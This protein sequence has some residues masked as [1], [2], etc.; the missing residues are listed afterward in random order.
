MKTL[1]DIG[2]VDATEYRRAHG[3]ADQTAM[4][5]DD[6]LSDRDIKT[7]ARADAAVKRTGLAAS[8]KLE[9]AAEAL[10]EFLHACLDAG[11][12]DRMGAGDGR[13][14]LMQSIMEY[15]SYLDGV[16]GKKEH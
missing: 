1:S 16:F 11:H 4:T 14:V 8:K 2:H 9:A 15:S 7:Q 6:W 5:G 13:R 12:Q 3:I 10:N